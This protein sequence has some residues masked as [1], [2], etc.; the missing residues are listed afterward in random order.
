MNTI[1]RRVLPLLFALAVPAAAVAQSLPTSQPPFLRVIR[2]DVKPGRGAEHTRHEMGWPAAFEKANSPDYYLAMESLTNNEAWYVIPAASYAAM[3]E[4]MARERGPALAAEMDRLGRLDG[5]LLNGWRAIE[6]RA[7]PE[8][9]HGAYPDT[10]KQRFWEVS[11]FR[12]RPGGERAFA[13][14]AKA[15]AAAADR[16]GV[17]PAYRVYE[18]QAGMPGPTFFIFSSVTSFGDFDKALAD[19][20]ATMKAMTEADAPIGKKFE[21]GLINAET[22]RLRLSPEMSYVPKEV[23]AADPAFWMPK[24]PAPVKAAATKAPAPA[25]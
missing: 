16:A 2:E 3:G 5:D 23:R 7:R 14:V 25:K 17:K 19:G 24:K 21:E 4:A 8:M 12:M 15:Y 13:D 22:F 11:V 20:E 18:V 6:L 9:S 10:S 1:Y